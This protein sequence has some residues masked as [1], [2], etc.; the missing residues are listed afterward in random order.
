MVGTNGEIVPINPSAQT[1]RREP[2][3]RRGGRSEVIGSPRAQMLQGALTASGVTRRDYP[4][5]RD[6]SREEREYLPGTVALVK[7]TD[8]RGT[9]G[10]ALILNVSP[11]QPGADE[12][13]LISHLAGWNAPCCHQGFI[14]TLR[15]DTRSF[16]DLATRGC[17]LSIPVRP[18]RLVSN[19]LSLSHIRPAATSIWNYKPEPGGGGERWRS[20]S[21]RST[22]SH[23]GYPGLRPS[24]PTRRSWIRSSPT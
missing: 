16:Y 2:D 15:Q 8:T 20:T 5:Y 9:I 19:L 12:S 6:Q 14:T 7:S 17:K 10:V 11:D 4:H 23:T 22:R 21:P 3:P 24:S 18:A 1:I 13:A